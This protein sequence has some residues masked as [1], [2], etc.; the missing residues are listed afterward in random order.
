MNVLSKLLD[1]AAAKGRTGFHPKCKNIALTH[2]CFA[3][4]LLVFAD[5]SQRSVESIL[6]VFEA[7][8]KM[9]GLKIS[10]EKSTLFLAGVGE[11]KKEE[12]LGHFPFAS[13]KLPVR[14]LGLPLL[15]KCMMGLGFCGSPFSMLSIASARLLSLSKEKS[16]AELFLS[17]G[18]SQQT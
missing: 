15:T 6:Q 5:G 1:E 12:I 17:K 7:F 10:L 9:S 16:V 11:Q 3:D 2:L 8:D 4:D 14:Y 18:T 13:G